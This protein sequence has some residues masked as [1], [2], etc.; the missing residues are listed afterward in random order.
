MSTREAFHRF[1]DTIEN[2]GAL[3]DYLA[4]FKQLQKQ[5]NGKLWNSLTIDQ[6]AELMAAYT[7]SFDADQLVAHESVKNSHAHWLR[8]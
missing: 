4:H 3:R 7:E 6:K 1:I 5:E 8:P 2:E